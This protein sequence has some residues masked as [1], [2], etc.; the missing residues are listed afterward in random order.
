MCLIADQAAAPEIDVEVDRVTINMNLGFAD[1]IINLNIDGIDLMPPFSLF[2]VEE[3]NPVSAK[4]SGRVI[5]ADCWEDAIKN[6]QNDVKLAISRLLSW[7]GFPEERPLWWVNQISRVFLFDPASCKMDFISISNDPLNNM[8]LAMNE[9]LRIPFFLL[10]AYLTAQH[11]GLNIHGSSFVIDGKGAVITGLSGAGKSTATKLINPDFVLS[12]DAAVITNIL[13]SNPIVHAAPVG[14]ASDGPGKVPLKALFFANKAD[15]F[16]I[17]RLSIHESLKR[18]LSE[19]QSYMRIFFEPT[20]RQY[21][22][23][24]TGLLRQLPVYELNFSLKDCP[25][26]QIN[27]CLSWTE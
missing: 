24:I 13:A 25:R 6:S 17:G 19:H 11:G 10:S 20:R 27:E 21:F 14:G 7:N 9:A 1:Q 3:A 2:E 23:L 8:V 22:S 12:D 4:L 26:D 15:R 18:L 5:S 16:S